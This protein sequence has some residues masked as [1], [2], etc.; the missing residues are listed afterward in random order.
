MN[1]KSHPG[2]HDRDD[3]MQFLCHD[4]RSPQLS[5]LTLLE[6]YRAEHGKLTP[7][8]ERIGMQVTNTLQLVE[9]YLH[10]ARAQSE[11]PQFE[12]INLNDLLIV[13]ADQLWE[14]ALAKRCRI[15]VDVPDTSVERYADRILLARL[16]TNLLDNALKYGPSESTVHCI[17]SGVAQGLLIGVE[18]EG[19]GIPAFEAGRA[20]ARFVQLN[21]DADTNMG[22]FGLGL[23][24]VAFSA[25]KHQGRLIMRRTQRGFLI[26]ALLPEVDPFTRSFLTTSETRPVSRTANHNTKYFSAVY[27]SNVAPETGNNEVLSILA[28]SR[29]RNR[30]DSVTG[31]LILAGHNF[32]Q[33]LEG[34]R[35]AVT[36]CLRRIAA[37]VRHSDMRIIAVNSHSTRRFCDWSMGYF[38]GDAGG[39]ERLEEILKA[40]SGTDQSLIEKLCHIASAVNSIDETDGLPIQARPI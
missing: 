3:A 5:I 36:A 16:V 39:S 2:G 37:D 35:E 10:L 9:G 18:D 24:F 19:T 11:S 6:L 7:L 14:Q 1:G 30:A 12:L 13:A 32:I 8:L 4:L 20:A 27:I 29:L 21:S 15:C 26:G 25:A 40:W 28:Q 31:I 34:E 33:Y 38:N 22:G 17:L 23:A